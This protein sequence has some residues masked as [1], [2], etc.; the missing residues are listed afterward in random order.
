MIKILRTV[1][2]WREEKQ[3]LRGQ[4]IGL[5]PTMGALHKGHASL[6]EKARQENDWV[7]ATI[8][9]NPTQFDDPNDLAA[10]PKTVDEDLKLLEELKV[11]Y[12]FLPNAEEMYPDSFHFSVCEDELSKEL[13]GK[14]RPGHF[15]GMLT[16]VLKLL[17]IFRADKAYFG[18]KDYQQLLLVQK[19][20]EAFFLPTLIVPCAIIREEDG[21]A[22]SSRNRHLTKEH[23]Q[24]AAEF[25][26]VLRSASNQQVAKQSLEEL[27]FLVD[28]VEDKFGR[29][30]GA[31]RVGQVRLIDNVG[32]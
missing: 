25:N 5:V 26:K 4:T 12:L 22:M 31:I 14:Y 15:D 29:R 6:F 30:L 9:I 17:N 8:F 21:L 13:C 1:K 2:E 7:V 19:L 24:K 16:V 11:D 27:G 28:Y 18:K 32:I 3:K 10:Y 20:C 23:R